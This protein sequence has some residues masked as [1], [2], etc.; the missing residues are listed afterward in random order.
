MAGGSR[1]ISVAHPDTAVRSGAVAAAPARI[2]ATPTG[3]DPSR[4]R[5]HGAARNTGE[6]QITPCTWSRFDP[7]SRGSPFN[8]QRSA[9]PLAR[10]QSSSYAGRAFSS[11][12]WFAVSDKLILGLVRCAAVMRTR[13]G[14]TTMTLQSRSSAVRR[15]LSFAA[16]GGAPRAAT[17]L[18][19]PQL[20]VEERRS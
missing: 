20:R 19:C 12:G 16:D 4:P 15:V 18:R 9:S 11:A 5:T 3:E 17:C 14:G 7:S 2:H 6:D 1:P 10:E 8:G 13:A